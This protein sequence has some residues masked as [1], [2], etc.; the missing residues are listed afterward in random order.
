[1]QNERKESGKKTGVALSGGGARAI[2]HLGVLKALDEIGIR[3]HLFSGTSF[4]AIAAA[5]YA[6]GYSPDITLEILTKHNIGMLMRP[7][8]NRG[9]LHLDRV[10]GLLLDYLGDISFEDLKIPLV[11]A[12]TDLN[13]GVTVYFSSGKLN[14]ILIASSSVPILYRPVKLGE[15]LLAD[16]GVLN[17]LPVEGLLRNCDV[18][19]GLHSNAV[20]HQA[21]IRTFRNIIERTFHLLINN[22]V[23]PQFQHFDLLIEPPELKYFS[24]LSYSKAREIFKIGYEY[25]LSLADRIREVTGVEPAPILRGKPE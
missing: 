21:N 18:K 23:Q 10:E 17:N 7:S 19:I 13:E 5:F 4:G 8:F 2:A 22:S 6:S 12:T 11:V 16:G 9:L 14:R 25:T 20:N 1:M 24:M 3:V 15:R